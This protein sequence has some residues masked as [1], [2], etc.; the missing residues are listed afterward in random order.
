MHYYFDV[1]KRY[2]DFNGRTARKEFWMFVLI[3]AIISI[4]LLTLDVV[5]GFQIVVF[6]PAAI[7]GDAAAGIAPITPTPLE[8]G[9]LQNIYALAVFLPC[10]GLAVRRLHDTGK[11]GWWWLMNF[12]C[13]I[14]WIVLLV[15]YVT[16][17]TEGENKYGPDPL[18]TD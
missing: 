11:S 14:G 5:L 7:G 1:L 18:S 3:N 16:R 10:L 6:Q 15:F 9:I 17:G 13:C 8:L 12:I 2:W 4:I